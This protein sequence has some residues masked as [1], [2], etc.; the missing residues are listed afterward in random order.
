MK[1]LKTILTITLICSLFV[2]LEAAVQHRRPPRVGL[3]FALNFEAAP[4]LSMLNMTAV[5]RTN[6]ILNN[7]LLPTRVYEGVHNNIHYKAVY[8]GLDRFSAP[9]RVQNI[10]PENAILSTLV[11]LNGFKADLIVS[12]GIAGGYSNRFHNGEIGVCA[13]NET[14]PYFDRRTD[15]GLPGY[16]AFGY[17]EYHCA[18]VPQSLL[19]ANDIKLARVSLISALIFFFFDRTILICD[20]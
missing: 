7:P 10:G 18:Q 1:L 15:F 9:S 14:T 6:G 12:A 2:S 16:G 4:F 11:L 8:A 20:L 19:D 5:N 13:N 3:L 17:G